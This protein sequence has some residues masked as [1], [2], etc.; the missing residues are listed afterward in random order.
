MTED[1][2][3]A[4]CMVRLAEHLMGHRPR[5]T[6]A[7]C[8]LRC[9]DWAAK[10][11]PTYPDLAAWLTYAADQYAT[12]AWRAQPCLH[13][14]VNADQVCLKCGEELAVVGRA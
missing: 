7:Q 8:H 1:A 12:L 11:A 9:L 3:F 6:L 10:A 14:D 4:K 13:A 5:L 2:L